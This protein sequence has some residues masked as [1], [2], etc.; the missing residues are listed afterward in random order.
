MNKN[1]QPYALRPT[2]NA[3]GSAGGQCAGCA[4]HQALANM[5]QDENA[6]MFRGLFCAKCAAHLHQTTRTA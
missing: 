2:T 3:K 1:P 4:A 6:G 5:V